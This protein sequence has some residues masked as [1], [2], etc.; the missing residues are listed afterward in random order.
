MIANI[1]TAEQFNSKIKT[2]EGHTIS[3]LKV[4]IFYKL[5]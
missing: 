4:V 1:G 2:T 3:K 5:D